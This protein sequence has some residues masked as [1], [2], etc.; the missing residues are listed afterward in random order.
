MW[1][2]DSKIGEAERHVGEICTYCGGTSL[3]CTPTLGLTSAPV[4]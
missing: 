3:V 1:K 2:T 4:Y